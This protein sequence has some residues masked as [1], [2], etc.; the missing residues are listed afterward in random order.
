MTMRAAAFTLGLVLFTQPQASGAVRAKEDLCIGCTHYPEAPDYEDDWRTTEGLEAG[1]KK[2]AR[3]EEKAKAKGEAGQRQQLQLEALVLGWQ[4]RVHQIFSAMQGHSCMDVCAVCVPSMQDMADS[5]GLKL[6]TVHIT[7]A[8]NAQDASLVYPFVGAVD[9]TL[10][11][12]AGAAAGIPASLLGFFGVGTLAGVG[13]GNLTTNSLGGGVFGNILGAVAGTATGA[14][15]GAASLAAIELFATGAGAYKGVGL[16]G[17]TADC[18]RVGF[19]RNS[20]G[21][22]KDKA[23]YSDQPFTSKTLDPHYGLK[24]LRQWMK[25]NEDWQQNSARQE[26][27]PTDEPAIEHCERVREHGFDMRHATECVKHS[28]LCGP[29]G[30]FVLPVPSGSMCKAIS[31]SSWLEEMAVMLDPQDSSGLFQQWRKMQEEI[32]ESTGFD[33]KRAQCVRTLCEYGGF[34]RASRKL[35]P[36]KLAYAAISEEEK[37]RLSNL[38][39]FL[40]SCKA[41]YTGLDGSELTMNS[42]AD[43]EA[44]CKLLN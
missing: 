44:I 27:H 16:T 5:E 40:S 2:L 3:V 33:G 24:R 26:I 25:D 10:G 20:G 6:N 15:S 18:K 14:V 38:F 19:E 39:V 11:T 21:S 37:R 29:Q 4:L 34:R 42:A 12:V 9:A 31:N 13:L 23:P 36:D 35:H 41:E 28:Q 32:R 43:R 17:M 1:L 7:R 22:T 30:G 8:K